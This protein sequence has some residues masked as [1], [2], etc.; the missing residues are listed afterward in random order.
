M[1]HSNE[2]YIFFKHLYTQETEPPF[3]FHKFICHY[4]DTGNYIE[5]KINETARPP[6]V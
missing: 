2:S 1:W 3:L 6:L 5:L 4:T